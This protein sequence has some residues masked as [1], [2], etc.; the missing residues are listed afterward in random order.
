MVAGGTV[1]DHEEMSPATTR[2]AQKTVYDG[3][4][5]IH[6]AQGMKRIEPIK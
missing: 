6:T 1:W 4:R 5:A 2:A 3:E